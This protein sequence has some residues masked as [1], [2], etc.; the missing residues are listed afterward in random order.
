MKIARIKFNGKILYARIEGENAYLLKGGFKSI[1]NGK[2]KEEESIRV[3]EIEKY[4]PPCNPSKIIG[5]ARNY[6]S[7]L[8]EAQ[9][10]KQKPY[11]EPDI[12]F[13]SKNSLIGHLDQIVIPS[14]IK[15]PDYEGE[16]VVIVS[17][18]GKNIEASRAKEYIFGYTIG[19]DITARDL[20][21]ERGENSTAKSLDTFAPVGPW[22]VTLDEIGENPD[23]EIKLLLNGN[24]MQNEKTSSMYLKVPDIIA[25][26]S[27]FVTLL[28]GDIIFT[29][30]PA[31]VGHF[32]NPPIYLKDGDKIDVYIEKIGTLTNSVR[33]ST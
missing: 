32:R 31:G 17:K 25:Y 10:V 8:K 4:L 12:F 7:H 16:L 26:I 14:F 9:S 5:L 3:Q 23:L 6:E 13:K 21:L 20:Q 1:L 30:T 22:I 19:N 33:Y 29:G 11:R 15:K 2:A 28:P 24:V 27:K 18:K